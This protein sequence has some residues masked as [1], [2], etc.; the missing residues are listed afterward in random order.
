[1]RRDRVILHEM[2]DV[3]SEAIPLTSDRISEQI[4]E[5]RVL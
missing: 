2:I 3:A 4:E 1:M 5:N